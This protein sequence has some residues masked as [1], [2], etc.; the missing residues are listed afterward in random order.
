MLEHRVHRAGSKEILVSRERLL[1]I[2]EA[3]RKHRAEECAEAVAVVLGFV[4]RHRGDMPA[5]GFERP[6]KARFARRL[7]ADQEFL[8][9]RGEVAASGVEVVACEKNRDALRSA[10][11]GVSDV[12]CGVNDQHLIHVGFQRP[13]TVHRDGKG[14]L[15]HHQKLHEA[16]V[17]ILFDGVAER[18]RVR[19]KGEHPD[20]AVTDQCRFEFIRPDAFFDPAGAGVYLVKRLRE[21]TGKDFEVVVDRN[22]RVAFPRFRNKPIHAGSR[23]GQ[24]KTPP[25]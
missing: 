16:V 23:N 5:H 9:E 14:A 18:H 1:L 6:D 12:I 13:D 11:C 22:P 7:P 24:K 21:E 25:V 15:S 8:E 2:L 17:R 4:W 19:F 20:H 3:F 10:G